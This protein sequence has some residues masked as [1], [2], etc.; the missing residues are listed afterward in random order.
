MF[1]VI[2]LFLLL[3]VVWGLAWVALA[4]YVLVP[5]IGQ[6]ATGAVGT[7]TGMIVG[8]FLMQYSLHVGSVRRWIRW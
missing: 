4:V 3:V 6:S 5:A 1:K 2:T 8:F 7:L